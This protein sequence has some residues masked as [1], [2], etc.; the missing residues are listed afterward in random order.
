MKNINGTFTITGGKFRGN[1]EDGFFNE[2]GTSYING[3]YF[4]GYKWGINSPSGKIW[5]HRT[6]AQYSDNKYVSSQGW[7]AVTASD[8]SFY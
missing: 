5:Y 4:T 6:D 7:S 3:G 1:T 8:L 2:K